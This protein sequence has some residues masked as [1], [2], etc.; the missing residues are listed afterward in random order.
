MN[1]VSCDR[2]YK[3]I[4]FGEKVQVVQMNHGIN[5]FCSEKCA[6]NTQTE[7]CTLSLDL[8]EKNQHLYHRDM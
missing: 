7:E 1:Y 3:P 6:F 4:P 5:I 8:V 2:C